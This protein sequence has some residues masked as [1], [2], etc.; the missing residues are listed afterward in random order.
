MVTNWFARDGLTPHLNVSIQCL[1]DASAARAEHVVACAT[2]ENPRG[3]PEDPVLCAPPKESGQRGFWRYV[4][5]SLF[6][7]YIAQTLVLF[8]HRPNFSEMTEKM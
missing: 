1:P 6:S 3:C 8:G 5:L 2:P 7:H 4:V